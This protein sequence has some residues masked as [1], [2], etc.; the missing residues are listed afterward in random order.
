MSFIHHEEVPTDLGENLGVLEY[1]LICGDEGLELQLAIA[2]PLVDKLKL[3]N[4]ITRLGVANIYHGVH[5]G[6]PLL[7][8]LDPIGHCGEGNDNE[9]RAKNVEHLTEVPNQRSALHSTCNA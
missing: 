6:D 2:A 8:L 1:Q 3:A 5:I 7:E 4:Y 9:K